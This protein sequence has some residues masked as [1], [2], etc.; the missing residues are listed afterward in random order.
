MQNPAGTEDA[1]ELVQVHPRQISANVLQ[2]DLRVHKIEDS[3]LEMAKIV[4]NIEV[5]V[6]NTGVR[7]VLPS[8]LHHG[9]A[10]VDA[11]HPRVVVGQSL[12]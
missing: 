3:A 12:G 1:N 8:S 10:H 4:G 2:H 11:I 5:V 7:G 6:S 9:V